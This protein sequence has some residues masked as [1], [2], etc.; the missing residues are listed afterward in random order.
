MVV[1]TGQYLPLYYFSGRY[2]LPA[3]PRR[4]DSFISLLLLALPA[5][6]G[7]LMVLPGAV[8]IAKASIEYKLAF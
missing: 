8:Y 3:V 4:A 2:N 7:S 6:T 5:C 1:A